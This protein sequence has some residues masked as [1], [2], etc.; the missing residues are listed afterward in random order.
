MNTTLTA[1]KKIKHFD[2]INHKKEK[3]YAKDLLSSISTKYGSLEDNVNSLSGGNQ[4]KIVLAKWLAADC[5]CIIFDEPTRGVDVGAKTEIYN[6][7][8]ELAEDGVAVIVIA[9][10]MVEI[11]GLC[12]RSVVMKDGKVVGELSKENLNEDNLIKMSMGV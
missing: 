10:D 3:K 7:I 11:I 12:D 6:L 2:V 8:N 9:S 4:Q 1:M 5:K